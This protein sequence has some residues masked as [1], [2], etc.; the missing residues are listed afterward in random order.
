MTFTAV[1]LQIPTGVWFTKHSEEDVGTVLH[2]EVQASKGRAGNSHTSVVGYSSRD[3]ERGRGDGRVAPEL[4]SEVPVHGAGCSL[5]HILCI[6]RDIQAVDPPAELR[7]LHRAVE[8]GVAAESSCHWLWSFQHR[9][10]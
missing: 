1:Y 9:M 6:Q 8:G 10:I 7:V 4:S 3:Q 2:W 5:P